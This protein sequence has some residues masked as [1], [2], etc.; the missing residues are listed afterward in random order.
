MPKISIIQGNM[1]T[2][3]IKVYKEHINLRVRYITKQIESE[4]IKL[5]RHKGE[6]NRLWP[7]QRSKSLRLLFHKYNK[8]GFGI[9]QARALR[10][11]MTIEATNYS[12]K[13]L[14]E[15]K[16]E[17]IHKY[18][19]GMNI[20]KLSILYDIPPM[21]IN[22]I[23]LQNKGITKAK[24]KNM[25]LHYKTSNLDQLKTY[26]EY[27]IQENHHLLLNL[28]DEGDGF[29]KLKTLMKNKSIQKYSK[30]SL[31]IVKQAIQVSKVLYL[32]DNQQ[33]V[34]HKRFSHEIDQDL[35]QVIYVPRPFYIY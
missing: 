23:I 20:I 24:V 12:F 32:S 17:I 28:K 15:L 26:I 31:T 35:S 6:F 13:K 34:A 16:D 33:Y 1:N 29:I 2:P 14:K 8:H 11:T 21:S 9:V 22:R 18:N 4:F 3:T 27:Y 5:V 30:S 25:A 7:N 19:T 10:R